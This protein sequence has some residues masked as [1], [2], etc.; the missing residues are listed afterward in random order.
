MQFLDCLG[1]GSW[2]WQLLSKLPDTV[3]KRFHL[4]RLVVPDARVGS[5]AERGGH[6]VERGHAAQKRVCQGLQGVKQQGLWCGRTTT[7]AQ[8][9]A[10]LQILRL[11]S[12]FILTDVRMSK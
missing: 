8:A 5:K 2:L 12:L 1:L 4:S 3:D 7:R 11:S 6:M 9:L 10:V